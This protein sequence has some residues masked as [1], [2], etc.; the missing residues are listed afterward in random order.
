MRTCLFVARKWVSSASRLTARRRLGESGRATSTGERA[1]RK[2]FLAC[3]PLAGWRQV[4]I[5]ERPTMQDFAQQ[6]R[7]LADEAYPEDEVVSLVLDSPVS[8]TG[9][10]PNT[11]PTASLHET[12]PAAEA[13]R[14]ARRLECHYAP[15][16]LATRLDRVDGAVG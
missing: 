8:S 16:P 15:K 10:A 5:T 12:F 11:H 7:W 1:A 14:I 4:G 3:E 9:Q 13:R 6:M 2:P